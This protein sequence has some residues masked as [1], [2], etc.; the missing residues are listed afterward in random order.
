MVEGIEH[1]RPELD[2][3]AL[4]YRE[5]LDKSEVNIPITRRDKDVAARSVLSR[6]RNAKRLRQVDATRQCR[7]R[8]EQDWTSEWRAG[9][10]LKLRLHRTLHAGASF[11]TTVRG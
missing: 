4:V 9:K 6:R 1:L 11:V 8:L 2:P 3:D 5:R 10:F 7:H